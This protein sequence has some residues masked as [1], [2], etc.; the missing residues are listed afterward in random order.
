MPTQAFSPRR[1][2]PAL[3]VSLSSLALLAG[4]GGGGDDATD[5]SGY[6]PD[7]G[8]PAPVLSSVLT[9]GF[10]G[11][12][13]VTSAEVN[14]RLQRPEYQNTQATLTWL[15]DLI[16][17]QSLNGT[18]YALSSSGAALAHEAGLTGAGELIAITD[19]HISAGHETLNAPG[20]VTVVNNYAPGDEHGTSVASV[21]AG[22][23]SGSF[24]GTAPGADILFG[25]YVGDQ[26]II[27]LGREA[28]RLRA[29][30]WNNSWGYVD[31][32]QDTIFASQTVF[33]NFFVNDPLGADYLDTLKDYANYGVVVFAASN[34]ES[35]QNSGIMEALPVYENDL[36]AGWLTVVNGVPTFQN[37]EVQSVNL[38]SSACWQSAR[39]CLTADGT[40]NAAV[41]SGSDYDF[42]TGTSFAAPQVSGALAILAQ[43][44]PTL[45]PHELRI[46]LLA[47]AQDDFFTPDATVELASGFTKGY[48]VL[49]GH[50]FLDIEAALRPIGVT[51]MSLASGRSVSTDAPVLLT[52]SG[53]GDAV[54]L[55]LAGTNVSVRD[56]LSANFVMPGQ[57]LSTSVR[58]AAQ[59]AA[60]LAKSM[61]TNLSADRLAAPTALNDP[62]AAFAGPVM[63][64]SAPDGSG[65]A[66]VLLPQSASDAM[67]FTLTRV[68]TEG[69]T[70]VELGLKLARDNGGL[71][72]LGGEDGAA[73]ASIA[74]G[75]TQDLGNGGFLTLS[76]EMGM[77][78]LGGATDISKATSA[79]FDALKLTAGQS[80]LF[81][82][83]DRLSIGVGMPV[84]I[85]SGET[86]LDL[87]VIRAG[88]AAGFE[89][90]DLNLA[91]EDRQVDME[92]TYQTA[93]ADG[94]EMKLSLIHS[95]NFGNR[96]GETDT[97]GALAIA[98]RF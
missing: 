34:Y 56:S 80:D 79:R 35:D 1:R 82:K 17:D 11:L 49:Y 33:N 2:L 45:T 43:A 5:L 58:P 83:G 73:M 19:E 37:G 41:G 75:I 97:S 62:F 78:D 30:A 52:G 22:N 60:L 12:A 69:A 74:L 16:G 8:A 38:I 54:E 57:A 31:A 10:A 64:L 20:K 26:N 42:T 94:L 84:A 25:T 47:S 18:L 6:L 36:E 85:A 98:F 95:D 3:F 4:C 70:K 90:V 50:G 27:D 23:E 96:A 7:F 24:V 71:M 92:V 39:W 61:R 14:L 9:G 76:G 55:S 40:W 72:S 29:V 44:F 68:L 67:G 87:P 48:S 51:S 77:T 65:S 66:A 88:A 21:A 86:V 93:L 13:G 53:F 89:S 91:P 59:A 32:N 28:L 63:T 81:T 15:R 46:R